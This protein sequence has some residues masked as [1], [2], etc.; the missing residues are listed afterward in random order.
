[1]QRPFRGAGEQLSTRSM[2]GRSGGNAQCSK[3]PSVLNDVEG[4]TRKRKIKAPDLEEMAFLREIVPFL[5]FVGENSGEK[6]FQR[7][8]RA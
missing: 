6:G 7:G 8:K 2:E 5:D 4:L 3:C 1:M